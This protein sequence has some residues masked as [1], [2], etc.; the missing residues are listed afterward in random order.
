MSQPLQPLDISALPELSR[1]VDEVQRSG[2]A[3]LLR[4]G[5]EDVALLTPLRKK[6]GQG[7]RS[8]RRRD[9]RSGPDDP[10]WNLLGIAHSSGPGDVAANKHKYLAEAYSAEFHE[11]DA[12]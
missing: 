1:L 6:P 3:R 2:E 12:S 11:P 7:M 10:L 8:S 9:R 5:A 4:R